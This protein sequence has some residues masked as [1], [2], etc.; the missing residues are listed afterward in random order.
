MRRGAAMTSAPETEGEALARLRR[1]AEKNL[2]FKSYI[3]QGYYETYTPGVILRNVFQNPAW[4]TAYTPYQPEISQGRLEALINFQ[5]M[6]ADLTGMAIANASMLDE[7]TAAAE[8]MTLCLRATK[9]AS[10][11][12]AVADDV[13]PQ[14]IDVV[15][16]RAEPLGIEVRVVPADEIAPLDAFGALVQYPGVDGEIREHATLAQA[17]HARGGL[18]RRRRGPAGTH[19][20]RGAGPMGRGR[21]GRQF[22]ALRR[23]HGL[24]RAACR[25]HGHAR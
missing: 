16:T 15:R 22:A 10:R 7:A 4:Y 21:R 24:R 3:G 14:T 17:L 18:S 13:L 11:L 20:S 9:S 1:I 6:V 23:A 8:A 25:L 19:A 12:F 2:V 5:T